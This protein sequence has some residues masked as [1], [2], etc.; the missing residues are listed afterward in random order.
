MAIS[1]FTSPNRPFPGCELDV[2]RLAT[3]RA[4]HAAPRA[5]MICCCVRHRALL[6]VAHNE[7]TYYTYGAHAP[8]MPSSERGSVLRPSSERPVVPGDTPMDLNRKAGAPAPADAVA[9]LLQQLH[10]HQSAQAV[11]FCTYD[12]GL[13]FY[14]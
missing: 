6:R 12:A 1:A 11:R 3:P 8:M 4:M 5:A 9:M 2:P 14:A 13:P 7:R 10:H